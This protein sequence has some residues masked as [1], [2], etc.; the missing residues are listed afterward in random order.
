MLAKVSSYLL[1]KMG[2]DYF[3]TPCPKI[4]SKWLKDRNI[5]PEIIKILAEKMGNKLCDI[6]LSSIFLNMS[7]WTNPSEVKYNVHVFLISSC[8]LINRLIIL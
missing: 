1:E 7:P 8:F 4:S 6:G 3:L 5:R 2:W